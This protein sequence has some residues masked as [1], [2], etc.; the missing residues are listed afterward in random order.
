MSLS[1]RDFT[2]EQADAILKRAV[3]LQVQDSIAKSSVGQNSISLQQ[4][5]QSAAEIGIEAAHVRKAAEELAGHS[6]TKEK[7]GAVQQ[8][9]YERE[10]PVQVKESD[11]PDLLDHLRTETRSQGQGQVIGGSLEWQPIP[12][13]G[14][15]MIHVQVAP[16]DGVTRVKI[17]ATNPFRLV[18]RI[19]YVFPV[20]ILVIAIVPVSSFGFK[21]FH[22]TELIPFVLMAA[23]AALI[24]TL[25]LSRRF[26]WS[27]KRPGGE[28]LMDTIS[29]WMEHLQASRGNA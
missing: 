17:R 4:L 27:K 5:Y 3:D 2:Q 15:E 21:Y 18:S 19:L 11:F 13:G 14:F 6:V 9:L 1:N 23:F 20:F 28:S 7:R 24:P 25:L 29:I 16:S 26:P 10:F 22:W 8:T 12:T